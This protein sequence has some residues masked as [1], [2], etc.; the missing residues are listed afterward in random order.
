MTRRSG[1]S[2]K[3]PSGRYPLVD[4]LDA[5]TSM[6]PQTGLYALTQYLDGLLIVRLDVGSGHHGPCNVR[7]R[8]GL[9][10]R[11]EHVQAFL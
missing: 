9:L 4:L 2:P 11:P 5:L 8:H 7:G 10:C 1:R 3:L 6:I